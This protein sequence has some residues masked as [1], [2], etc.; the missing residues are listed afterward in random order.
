MFQGKNQGTV[1]LRKYFLIN[2]Y[3]EAGK[4]L[5]SMVG[6]LLKLR[7]NA[8]ATVHL[9]VAASIWTAVGLMLIFRG[10]VWLKN[11]DSLWIIIPALILGTIKS[12]FIL[13]RTAKKSIARI[14]S[15]RDGKCIGGVYSIKTWALV[16]VMMLAGFLLR[17][18]SFP[19][20]FLGLFYVAIGWALVFSSRNGWI[21]WQQRAGKR[22]DPA[23][24]DNP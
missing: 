22:S 14:V 16:L 20:E 6:K 8:S 1:F 3:V 15:S 24:N 5:F 18:S 19:K 10:T 2:P 17:N 9:I 11:I 4:P 7:P 13:D 23:D 12:Y 21:A